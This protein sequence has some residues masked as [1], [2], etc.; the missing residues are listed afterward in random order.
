MADGTGVGVWVDGV[1]SVGVDVA[2]WVAWGREVV[3]VV[4][5]MVGVAGTAWE[6]RVAATWVARIVS[7]VV[8]AAC[9]G[10]GEGTTVSVGLDPDLH[11]VSK[12]INNKRTS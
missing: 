2:V 9:V 4:A 5:N 1:I 10:T 6:V 7:S 12:R 3:V 11:P 8:V